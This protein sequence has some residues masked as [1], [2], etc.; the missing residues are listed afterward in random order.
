MAAT[1][2]RVS[3]QAREE[4]PPEIAVGGGTAVTTGP[5]AEQQRIGGPATL[6]LR[7]L[8]V[9][10]EPFQTGAGCIVT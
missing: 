9:H 5:R 4:L 8:V 2:E 7:A 6:G 10:L 1:P 3:V